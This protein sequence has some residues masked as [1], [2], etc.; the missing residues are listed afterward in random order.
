MEFFCEI[1]QNFMIFLYSSI[2]TMLLEEEVNSG[3]MEFIRELIY[4]QLKNSI[5]IKKYIRKI[6]KT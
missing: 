2:F 3:E 1:V 5:Y 4:Q 6:R